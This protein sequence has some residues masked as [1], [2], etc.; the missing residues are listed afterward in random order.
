MRPSARSCHY[1]DDR[2][3]YMRL[4]G[5]AARRGDPDARERYMP[6][7]REHLTQALAGFEA[8]CAAHDGEPAR[9]ALAALA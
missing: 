7:L 2:H 4:A 6:R 8:Q 5:E 1:Y 9:E 3:V